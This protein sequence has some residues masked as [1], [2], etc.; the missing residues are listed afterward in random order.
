MMLGT[1]SENDCRESD[2]RPKPRAQAKVCA[3]REGGERVSQTL[4][5]VKSSKPATHVDV[6]ESTE[7]KPRLGGLDEH[8][9]ADVLSADASLGED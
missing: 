3:F 4:F 1:K 8:A 2:A 5:A 6:L 9:T 7:H